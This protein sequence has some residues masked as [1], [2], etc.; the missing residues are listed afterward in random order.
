[1]L[2]LCIGTVVILEKDMDKIEEARK[3]L[4]DDVKKLSDQELLEEITKFELLAESILELTE[5][6][7]FEGKELSELISE[8]LSQKDNFNLSEE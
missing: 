7:L 4:G 8:F 1:M 5:K 3:I 2:R 6:E